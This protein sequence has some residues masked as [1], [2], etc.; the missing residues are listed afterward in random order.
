MKVLQI[1]SV[2]GIRSTGR[3]CTDIADI[4]KAGGGDCRV[5]YGRESVPEKYSSIAVRIG[6]EGDANRH[7]AMSR[8]F[9]NTG[10]GSK[11]ATKEFIKWVKEYDP[12]VIHLQNIH[13]YY[14]NLELLFNYLKEAKKPV[15][16]TLHDCWAFTGHCAHFDLIDCRKWE[17]GGCHSCPQK[18]RYPT[19]MVFDR[20]KKNF[21]EKKQLFTGLSNMTI[22]T[23]SQWLADLVKRSFLGEY[24]IK[25]IHNGIDLSV[26]KPTPTGDFRER[27]GLQDK[28]VLLGVAS[29]WGKSKG[30][31][32]FK[33]MS[34]MK[35]DNEAIVLVGLKPEQ[36]SD[37]PD[38]II[39]ISRT[40]NTQELAEIYTAADVFLNPT[41]EDT[42]PT[43][44][45]EAQACGTPVV[46]YRTGGSVESVP[47]DYSADRGNAQALLDKARQVVASPE[48]IDASAFSRDICY[49]EY[50]D[51]Y[52]QIAD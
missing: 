42:Y 37:L 46:T 4:L 41:Y 51:L 38:G 6:N 23:P 48:I 19:S 50:I 1:N 32:D 52:R 15:V 33:K 16:W 10:H 5:G 28:T 2:C 44:N 36:I 14:V 30:L 22:V 21:I 11:R 12:D 43:V 20:S 40:N 29:A 34:E 13:G 35:S 17:N 45:L 47:G 39:G 9:D 26:F 7:A 24:P 3:I 49:G 31:Y 27:Y 8:I 18:K 25:V